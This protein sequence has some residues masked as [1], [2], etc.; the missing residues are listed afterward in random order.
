M[1]TP[2][3]TVAR[4]EID[5]F[6]GTQGPRNAAI[7][8]VSE[9]WGAEEQNKELPFVGTSGLEFDRI[10][11]ESGID[12]KRCFIT[13]VIPFKPYTNTA[14][15]FLGGV[16]YWG[17]T[18][19]PVVMA[20]LKA[21]RHQVKTVQPKIVIA[22]GNY[23]FWAMSE[24]CPLRKLKKKE[25][26]QF[27]P[28]GITDWRSSMVWSRQEYGTPIPVLPTFHPAY[29]NRNW[30]E[31]VYT[32]HDLRERV[33]KALR[34][35]WNGP[36]VTRN[37][38][39]SFGNVI[40][41]LTN[42]L[43][44]ANVSPTPLDLVC[45][46]ETKGR[47]ITCIGFATSTSWSICIPLVKLTEA[48]TLDSYWTSEEELSI[49]KLLRRLL[50]HPNICLIGQNFLYD[51]QYLSVW[52]MLGTRMRCGFDTMYAY[53]TLF[54]GTT[55]SLDMLSTL[56][57]EYHVF[58]KHETQG[59]SETGTLEQLL[60]YNCTD[61]LHTFEIAL[62]LRQLI[63]AMGMEDQWRYMLTTV[64]TVFRMMMRGIRRDEKAKDMLRI[65]SMSA[66]SV[67]AQWL[68]KM[69]PQS[70]IEKKQKVKWHSSP[71]QCRTIFY[72]ILGL[73]PSY[74]RKTKELTFNDE[75]LNTLKKKVPWLTRLWEVLADIR[76]LRVF[77][78]L[79]FDAM[80]DPD[81]RFRPSFNP[82]GTETFRLSSSKNP[83]FRGGNLQNISSGDE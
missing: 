41:F 10:L 4:L 19:Q 25:G 21:L 35:E 37:Y 53:H 12:R 8:I 17:C 51:M 46:I 42:T 15:L 34:G 66:I 7:M 80:L 9:V 30:G 48:R 18:P 55:K 24:L 62:N 33:P 20:G 6:Y 65:E 27:V 44:A 40:Q 59:W 58:W 38:R 71:A 63:P 26:G 64:H 54:P 79:Y 70:W 50:T 81:K 74:D 36:R 45:D 75:A 77:T 68:E 5:P 13:N 57:C 39:P 61:C 29:I 67:R 72:D 1:L 28:F 14:E 82:S 22:L 76:S 23:G 47:N 32:V 60:D 78:G 3:E 69:V 2:S 31:R 83:F 52:L 49:I 73:P 16:P 56:F 11:A 43:E